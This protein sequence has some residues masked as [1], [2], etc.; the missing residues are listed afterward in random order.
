MEKSAVLILKDYNTRERESQKVIIPA[1]LIGA[2]FYFSD[3]LKLSPSVSSLKF[4]P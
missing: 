4:T 1:H 2:G 3:K